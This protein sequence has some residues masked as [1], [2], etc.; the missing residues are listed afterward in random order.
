M[1][2]NE[3][4]IDI[5]S[6]YDKQDIARLKAAHKWNVNHDFLDRG[7]FDEFLAAW[8][9]VMPLYPPFPSFQEYVPANGV[10]PSSLGDYLAG[11]MKYARARGKRPVLCEIHSRGRAGALRAAFG[12]FHVAQY[13]DPIS[14]FGSFMRPLIE[15]GEWGFLAFPLMELG[16]GGTHPLYRLVPEVWRVPVLPWP[17]HNRAQRWFSAVQ[18]MAMVASPRPDAVEKTFRWYLFSWF[19]SDLAALSYSDLSLDIDRAHDDRS[20]RRTVVDALRSN[21]GVAV[22]FSDLQKFPRYYEFDSFDTAAVCDQVIS[23]MRDALHDGR[24]DSAVRALG[25]RPPVTSPAAA[26]EIL[27][28][29]IENSLTIMN[30]SADLEHISRETWKAVAARHRKIWF[31]RP[32]RTV[33]RYVYPLAAPLARAARRGATRRRVSLGSAAGDE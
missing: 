12:G 11:L 16:I 21:G 3:A 20:Y 9:E 4:I 22:D 2:F 13:R 7:D 33:A 30:G 31:N 14:Q 15:G 1:C 24:L 10:L 8:D 18:Y 17:S 25:K 19:L 23:A 29:K 27:L 6:Y 28:T 26:A 32:V 5:F